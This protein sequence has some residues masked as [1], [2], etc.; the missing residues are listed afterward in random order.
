MLINA[1]TDISRYRDI[2]PRV[3]ASLNAALDLR[4]Q[5]GI[6]EAGAGYEVAR[7]GLPLR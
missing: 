2:S 4:I 6:A 1:S 3:S 5:M 7:F